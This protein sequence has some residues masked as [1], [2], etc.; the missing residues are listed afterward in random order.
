M[1]QRGIAAAAYHAGLRPHDR[2]AIHEGF[3][4]E[5]VEVV[6]PTIAF[7][8]GIDKPNVRFVFHHDIS[9]SLD[10]HDQETGR[11]G[12]DGESAL[13]TLFYRPEDL[14]LRRFQ[15]GAGDLAA[16]EVEPVIT[17]LSRASGIVDSDLVRRNFDVSDTRLMRILNRLAD[18]D[19]ID[20]L[21]DGGISV[22]SDGPN[23]A[24]AAIEAAEEQHRHRCL[25][26]SRLQMMQ[27]YA[28]LDTCR[29]TFLLH[30]FS[31]ATTRR[32]AAATCAIEA[33]AA[34]CRTPRIN[35]PSTASCDTRNSAKER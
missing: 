1:G 34:Q 17:A 31:E 24:A 3:R 4:D 8:M 20:L 21:P 9:D 10:S 7:G 23:P 35:S 11:A 32:A 5:T 26:R 6:A 15:N 22:H 16:D 13:A 14:N 25:V 19:A 27:Q 12:R 30:Y 2:E 33:T 18:V 29:R 28:E